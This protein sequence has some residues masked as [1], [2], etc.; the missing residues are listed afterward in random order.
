[1]RSST[2]AASKTSSEIPVDEHARNAVDVVVEAGD[3]CGEE[4]AQPVMAPNRLVGEGK[5]E[6]GVLAETGNDVVDVLL[7]DRQEVAADERGVVGSRAREIP[8]ASLKPA[9]SA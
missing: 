2:V 9:V 3:V 8:S 7:V 6:G 4:L 5:L 1:M